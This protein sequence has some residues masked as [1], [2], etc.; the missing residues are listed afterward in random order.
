MCYCW[1][2]CD[3]L[4][5]CLLSRFLS[6]LVAV[7]STGGI[8]KLACTFSWW[9]HEQGSLSVGVT[10]ASVGGVC[11]DINSPKKQLLENA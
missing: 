11:G 4:A 6:C 1:I 10:S 2:G 7:Q 9:C 3:G 5:V 8:F